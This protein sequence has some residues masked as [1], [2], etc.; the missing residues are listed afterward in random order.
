MYSMLCLN[1]GLA[2]TLIDEGP[3]GVAWRIL[4]AAWVVAPVCI[5]RFLVKHLK[6]VPQGYG[7]DQFIPYCCDFS[8][9]F[10]TQDQICSLVY[11]LHDMFQMNFLFIIIANTAG[12][13]SHNYYC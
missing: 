10:W 12:M 8:P 13:Q 7:V 5:D 11:W 1:T 3:G 2:Q 9:C 6:I 4:L